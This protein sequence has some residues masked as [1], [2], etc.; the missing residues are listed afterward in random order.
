MAQ[1]VFMKYILGMEEKASTEE[2]LMTKEQTGLEFLNSIVPYL[3][4]PA[5]I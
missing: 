5:F 2:G 3:A 4:K 1:N